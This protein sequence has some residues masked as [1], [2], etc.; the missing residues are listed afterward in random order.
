VTVGHV[1]GVKAGCRGHAIKGI[2]RVTLRAHRWRSGR[3]R[4]V[5]R[6]EPLPALYRRA[7][8]CSLLGTPLCAS[9][10][11]GD[12]LVNGRWP[13]MLPT[14]KATWRKRRLT[15]PDVVAWPNKADNLMCSSFHV[16]STCTT[17]CVHM[18][19]FW[20]HDTIPECCTAY[21]PVRQISRSA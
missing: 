13:Q 18:Y 15:L 8:G 3:K 4:P 11:G 10:L 21:G 16:G 12:V 14:D 5:R 19:F 17:I 1:A 6:R 2:G 9:L 7:S 20:L